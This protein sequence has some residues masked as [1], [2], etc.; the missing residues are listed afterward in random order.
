MIMTGKD[1][2]AKSHHS[3]RIRRVCPVQITNAAF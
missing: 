3:H 2:A 1:L